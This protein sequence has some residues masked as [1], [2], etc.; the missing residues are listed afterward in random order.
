MTKG[1]LGSWLEKL[2]EILIVLL[3]LYAA[4]GMIESFGEHF[5][6]S[7]AVGASA[8]DLALAINEVSECIDEQGSG[9][10][11]CLQGIEVEISVP[12]NVP[13][14]LDPSFQKDPLWII[15][16]NTC[17]GNGFN[18]DGSTRCSPNEVSAVCECQS[19]WDS[20]TFM[21]KCENNLCWGLVE[22][23]EPGIAQVDKEALKKLQ[24]FYILDPCYAIVIVREDNDNRGTIEICFKQRL[25][26]PLLNYCYGEVGCR[27]SSD[28]DWPEEGTNVWNN[29]FGK[30][31]VE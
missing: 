31:C 15:Q 23:T 16:Y 20:G 28:S 12:Q 11:D 27:I 19:L 30:K 5:T 17:V 1:T 14:G 7:M 2:I 18:E 13:N 6:E 21:P 10:M 24:P 29:D 9:S 3:V 8:N 22:D 25:S 26:E 4:W